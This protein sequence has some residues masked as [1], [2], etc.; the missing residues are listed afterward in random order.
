MNATCS[1]CAFQLLTLGT[2]YDVMTSCDKLWLL[3]TAYKLRKHSCTVP[4]VPL[5]LAERSTTSLRPKGKP[6][7]PRVAM[8]AKVPRC[9][10]MCQDVPRQTSS[11]VKWIQMR[12][13]IWCFMM[14]QVPEDVVI[15]CTGFARSCVDSLDVIEDVWRMFEGIFT[16]FHE[17]SYPRRSSQS[18]HQRK[19]RRFS[20]S[21]CVSSI[22]LT[23]ESIWKLVLLSGENCWFQRK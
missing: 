7:V 20:S 5:K 23:S 9:A 21:A 18:R 14:F 2:W 6:H 3:Q 8:L 16:M 13:F 11:N 22:N 19:R 1:T 4:I 12:C 10:K 17:N 15:L